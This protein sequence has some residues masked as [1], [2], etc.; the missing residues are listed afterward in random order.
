MHEQ[1]LWTEI[2][3]LQISIFNVL[4]DHNTKPRLAI[5]G[6]RTSTKDIDNSD[7]LVPVINILNLMKMQALENQIDVEEK[8]TKR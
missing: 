2:W 6:P 7:F 1:S 4:Q 5:K 8:E 3:S